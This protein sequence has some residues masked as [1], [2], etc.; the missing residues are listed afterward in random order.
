MSDNYT[1]KNPPFDRY[2]LQK[3]S[4]NLISQCEKDRELALETHEYFKRRVEENPTDGVSK[5]LMVDCLKLVQSSKNH[6]VKLVEML[7]KVVTKAGED[8]SMPTTKASGKEEDLSSS[9]SE[10]SKLIRDR[11]KE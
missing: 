11:Q 9:F 2:R 8:S 3:I 4:K 10:L 7:W 5:N 1:L 6:S